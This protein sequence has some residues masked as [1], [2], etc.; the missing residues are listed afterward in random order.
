MIQ[1]KQA[2]SF[3][4]AQEWRG[5]N[6]VGRD[7]A[8]APFDAQAR[9]ALAVVIFHG[10]F[11]VAGFKALLEAGRAGKPALIAPVVNQLL[12]VNEESDKAGKSVVSGQKSE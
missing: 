10:N 2:K 7:R 11:V 3:A 9:L 8:P 5:K 4:L 12:A 6:R 1:A